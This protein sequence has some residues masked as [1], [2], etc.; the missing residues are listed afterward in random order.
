MRIRC[1]GGLAP[2]RCRRRTPRWDTAGRTAGAVGLSEAA[3]QPHRRLRVAPILLILP[4]TPS[5]SLILRTR[6]TR[7]ELRSMDGDA[8]IRAIARPAIGLRQAEVAAR[9]LAEPRADR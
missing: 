5:Y 1:P 4:H 2:L 3:T 7:H 9:A 6:Y 8:L